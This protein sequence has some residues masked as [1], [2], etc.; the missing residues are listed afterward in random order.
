MKKKRILVDLCVLICIVILS[1]IYVAVRFPGIFRGYAEYYTWKDFIL[2]HWDPYEDV[3][4]SSSVSSK[5]VS[6]DPNIWFQVLSEEKIVGQTIYNGKYIDISV[7][8]GRGK[9]IRIFSDEIG[10]GPDFCGLCKY[11]TE[12]LK[13]KV[14]EDQDNIFG[15]KYNEIVFKKILTE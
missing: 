2:G 6:E 11:G 5:W 8:F 4:P 1:V 14:Y 3:R 15:G 9:H 7:N 13:V 12:E 10:G